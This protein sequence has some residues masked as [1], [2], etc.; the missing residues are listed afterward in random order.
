MLFLLFPDLVYAEHAWTELQLRRMVRCNRRVE[1]STEDKTPETL[2]FR[3]YLTVLL[4]FMMRLF[5]VSQERLIDAS[6]FFRTCWYRTS[7]VNGDGDG[8]G[9]AD[10][11]GV[12]NV[13]AGSGS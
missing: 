2:F 6:S 7:S 3:P 10:D 12:T 5:R 13:D 9:G 4:V 8:D 1:L 11:G